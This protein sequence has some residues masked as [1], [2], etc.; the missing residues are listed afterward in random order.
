MF[1]PGGRHVFAEFLLTTV[2]RYLAPHT[3]PD[4]NVDMPDWLRE[5]LAQLEE[6]RDGQ[7]PLAEL[8]RR[9]G[10]CHEHFTREFSKRLGLTPA[11]YLTRLR[12]ERAARLL[13]TSNLKISAICQSCGFDSESHFFRQFRRWKGMLPS[14]YRRTMGSPGI[15]AP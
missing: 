7:I 11:C 5:T 6:D 10:K 12:I 1:D 13:A 3:N 2:T 15:L 9:S 14:A 8:V 4:H